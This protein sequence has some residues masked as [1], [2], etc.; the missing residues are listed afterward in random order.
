MI[1][2]ASKVELGN[3]IYEFTDR[4]LTGIKSSWAIWENGIT[5]KNK[6]ML[7]KDVDTLFIGAVQELAII[8]PKHESI[9]ITII[10]GK[11]T[12]N[13]HAGSIGWV[14]SQKKNKIND[15]Y[16]FIV[17]K[18]I[19]RQLKDMTE[20]IAAG[21]K[22]NFNRFEISSS[23]ICHKRFLDG[24][25]I[26]E[27]YR[28]TGCSINFGDFNVHYFGE[29]GH[30]KQKTLGKVA[31]TPNI[32]LAQ[33][34]I[35]QIAKENIKSIKQNCLIAFLLYDSGAFIKLQAILKIY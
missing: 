8:I 13:I 33:T 29:K 3:V 20:N 32:H 28:L 5:H 10:A 22:V 23:G 9:D 30:L 27:I 18:I 4:R 19:E 21:G 26:I 1:Q 6:V 25:D 35:S 7:W 24:Y 15:I 12:I 16:C 14:G 17:S 11:D 34:W 2:Y 31:E